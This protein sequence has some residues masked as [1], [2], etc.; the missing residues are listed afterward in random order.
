MM[1]ITIR[2]VDRGHSKKECS[3]LLWCEQKGRAG[4]GKAMNEKL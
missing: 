4:R 3:R 2:K 1:K